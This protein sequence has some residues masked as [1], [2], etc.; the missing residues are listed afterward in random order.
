MD[1]E[2]I[3]EMVRLTVQNEMANRNMNSIDPRILH[4]YRKLKNIVQGTLSHLSPIEGGSMGE[5]F[6]KK[7]HRLENWGVDV[8]T[9]ELENSKK[10][11]PTIES[12]Y[13]EAL[14]A[15][16]Q[17]TKRGTANIKL[18]IPSFKS[19][20]GKY[21]QTIVQSNFIKNKTY[22]FDSSYMDRDQ[23]LRDKFFDTI[24]NQVEIQGGGTTTS[25]ST[26]TAAVKKEYTDTI[27][28]NESISH[29]PTNVSH[30]TTKNLKHHKR[31]TAS[32][33]SKQ[34]LVKS[35]VK[36]KVKNI[37][38]PTE[39]AAEQHKKASFFYDYNDASEC[40]SMAFFD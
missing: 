24:Y 32:H 30:L 39:A 33:I 28:A 13:K 9:N 14:V 40:G 34:S 15:Y 36:S 20:L 22:F 2:Q 21:Y 38:L 12:S 18:K 4:F 25:S 37:S 5:P 3:Q 19:F 31:K 29:A 11:Y 1:K 7:L 10:L 27:R 26:S 16:A 8:G 35:L 23:F 17:E 6:Q